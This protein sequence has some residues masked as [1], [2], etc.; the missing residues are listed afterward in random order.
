MKLQ[1]PKL[2]SSFDSNQ[3]NWVKSHN[4]SDLQFLTKNRDGISSWQVLAAA[5]VSGITEAL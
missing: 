1:N 2:S 4:L 5:Y 3:V